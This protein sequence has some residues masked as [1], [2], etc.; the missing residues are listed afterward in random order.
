LNLNKMSELQRVRLLQLF[1]AAGVGVAAPI[2]WLTGGWP[3]AG[4]TTA[5]TMILAVLLNVCLLP[6]K[7]TFKEL[8]AD[9]EKSDED[10]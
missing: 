8:F 5:L 3:A 7:D 1:I 10:M 2:V 9:E 4:L 6:G